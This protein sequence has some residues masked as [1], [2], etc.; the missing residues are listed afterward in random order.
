MLVPRKDNI[1]QEE[2]KLTA[3]VLPKK[4]LPSRPNWLYVYISMYDYVYEASRTAER[5]EDDWL[6]GTYWQHKT[7]LL[8]SSAFYYRHTNKQF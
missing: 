5:W 2:V 1:D 3:I 6:P 7:N 8:F 4:Q